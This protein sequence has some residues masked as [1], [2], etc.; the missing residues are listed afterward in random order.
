MSAGRDDGLSVLRRAVG[1]VVDLLVASD[2][3]AVEDLTDGRRLSADDLERVVAACGSPLAPLPAG[4]LDDLDVVEIEGAQP[5]ARSVVVDIWTA[6]GR[7]DLTLE[8]R[9]Q[10]RP[11]GDPAPVSRQAG[12]GSSHPSIAGTAR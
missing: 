10:D 12:R 3:Q 4:S 5:P 7:G 2:Y 8:L 1:R 9:V 11:H 6:E